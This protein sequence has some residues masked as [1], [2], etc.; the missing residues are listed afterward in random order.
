MGYVSRFPV[1]YERAFL[2]VAETLEEL[3]LPWWL[4]EGS[5]IWALRYGRNHPT[6]IFDEVDDDIDVMVEIGAVAHWDAYRRALTDA[7]S[8]RGWDNL[9]RAQTWRA[10][11]ARFDKLV[12]RRRDG[13]VS[14]QVDVHSYYPIPGGY[15]V[16]ES[17][18]AYP[19]QSWG[20]VVPHDLIKPLGT[21]AAYGMTVPSPA[22]PVSLLEGW[23]RGEYAGGEIAL[24]D[25]AIGA[26]ERVVLK[27]Y[28][29]RLSHAG[30]ASFAQ[31][32]RDVESG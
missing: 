29:C 5:L 13:D 11:G 23:H 4:T 9:H 17:S 6:E 25:R 31:F 19:F 1:L 28:A 2:E 15:T 27:A 18:R 30:H 26:D 22:Q 16:H 14:V 3:G 21:V 7:L 8:E 12:A 10:P 24:P 32:W 20:G